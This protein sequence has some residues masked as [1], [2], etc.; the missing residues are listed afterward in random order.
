MLPA[1]P[2]PREVGRA[3]H[4]CP[5]L[6]QAPRR[7]L[8]GALSRPSGGHSRRRCSQRSRVKSWVARGR[9]GARERRTSSLGDKAR[10]GGARAH[11]GPHPGARLPPRSARRAPRRPLPLQAGSGTGL[12]PGGDAG[13]RGRSLPGAPGTRTAGRLGARKGAWWAPRQEASFLYFTIVINATPVFTP[14]PE[15]G[16]LPSPPG[17]ITARVAPGPPAGSRLPLAARP[18]LGPRSEGGGG[19]PAGRRG[20]ARPGPGT[21]DAHPRRPRRFLSALCERTAA[22]AT[23]LPR[24]LRGRPR[25]DLAE[26]AEGTLRASRRTPVSFPRP[27]ASALGRALGWRL[28]PGVWRAWEGRWV[29][30]WKQGWESSVS[31]PALEHLPIQPLVSHQRVSVPSIQNIDRYL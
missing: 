5:G 28:R 4:P 6:L 11:P 30:G 27:P 15:S 2:A 3:L 17:T 10:L 16:A 7:G 22:C 31:G 24:G 8:C 29:E 26:E 18:G 1:R 21:R 19:R 14:E 13:V 20:C 9:R 25:R 12:S 23:V